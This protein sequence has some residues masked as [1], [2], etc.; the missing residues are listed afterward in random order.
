MNTK[1][2]LASALT[3]VVLLALCFT[4]VLVAQ[5]GPPAK[6]F[7]LFYASAYSQWRVPVTVGTSAS[8]AGTLTLAQGYVVLPGGLTI[9]PFGTTTRISVYDA[10]TDTVTPSGVSGCSIGAV[11][12]SCNIT[13]TYG[14]AHGRGLLIGSGSF[15]FD[16]AVRDAVA[17]GGGTVVVDASF[18]G[19]SATITGSAAGSTAVAVLDLRSGTPIYYGW[20][21][22]A[23]AIVLNVTATGVRPGLLGTFQGT[24]S[25]SI[26]TGNFTVLT[27]PAISIPASVANIA[28]K[29]IR[30]HGSGVYT[31]AAASLLNAD[32]A[33]CTVSGCGSGTVVAP[34]GCV[35]TSTNQANN[36]TN[37][38]FTFDCTFTTATTGAAGTLMAKA[39]AGF[40]LGAATT[41]VQSIFADTA[42]A[43]SA[44]VDLTVA[45]FVHPRFKFTTSN[46]GNSATLQEVSVEV[47]N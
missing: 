41:A 4:N 18:G 28:G 19:T 38:Q 40:N 14:A 20:N 2:L 31:N 5:S 26:T 44:A 9:Q 21:G 23:Y 45:E 35:V 42:T 37:G 13:A 10:T 34:A 24:S 36:L 17:Y 43:A 32:I 30:V 8:G 33:L 6:S 22:S 16:E 3:F 25:T 47:L 7:G 11:E 46:A 29:R 15:G 1:R 12:N 27:G 39:T